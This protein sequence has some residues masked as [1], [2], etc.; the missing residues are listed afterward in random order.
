[1]TSSTHLGPHQV[2]PCAPP[3]AQPCHRRSFLTTTR[4]TA[5]VVPTSEA[6]KRG[7]GKVVGGLIA[8]IALV[9][10]GGFAVSKIVAGNEGGAANPD[11]GRYEADR[12]PR[13]RGR[14]GRRRPVAARRAR[15]VAPATDRLRRQSQAARDRRQHS[16]ASTRSA[17]STSPSTMS[18]SSQT[19]TNVDDIADIRITATST[20]S[21]DGETRADRPPADR[22]GV[23]RRHG[24][25]LASEPQDSDVDWHL[26][27][28]KRDG[29]WYL[30]AFYSIAE[31]ARDGGDDIPESGIVAAVGA[32]TPD[33][34]VQAI[35]DAVDDVD[36]EALI[37]ALN[38][39]EAEA[40]QRYAP[41]FVDEA[42]DK[43]STISTPR[44]PSPTPS[45]RSPAT[46]TAARCGR[47]VHA[48]GVGRRHTT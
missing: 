1:M 18:M 29:R 13:G 48:D 10:A 38:P 40:L 26:T 3:M 24:P 21:I 44:S 4:P 28:V 34:A 39:N 35:F 19:E 6:G 16:V 36:L 27:T 15:H 30:S 33:G 32:D 23:R 11:R 14:A 47:Q 31:N 42:Q 46:A 20:A 12:R 9:A 8:V 41:M 25:T 7:R 2:V 37:A 43:L 5:T 22:R 17:V 45:S